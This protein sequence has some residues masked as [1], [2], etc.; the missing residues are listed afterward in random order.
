MSTRPSQTSRC[1]W[2]RH[3]ATELPEVPVPQPP[4]VDINGGTEHQNAPGAVVP[5]KDVVIREVNGLVPMVLHG[6]HGS[7]PSRNNSDWSP[8]MEI[9][10]QPLMGAIPRG[11]ECLLGL[12]GLQRLGLDVR[13]RERE[14]TAVGMAY[15]YRFLFDSN[16]HLIR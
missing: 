7:E 10:T 3:Q 9:T 14:G 5:V 8:D 11:L 2:L 1:C 13:R 12:V 15:R 6:L 16:S 4:R